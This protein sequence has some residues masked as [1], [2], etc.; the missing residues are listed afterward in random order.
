M[1]GR[2]WYFMGGEESDKLSLASIDLEKERKEQG[3]M[4]ELV[5]FSQQPLVAVVELRQRIPLQGGTK[6]ITYTRTVPA[7]REYSERKEAGLALYK[8][9]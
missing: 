9:V 3:C 7:I 4:L 8:W 2:E 1:K 6:A 5:N